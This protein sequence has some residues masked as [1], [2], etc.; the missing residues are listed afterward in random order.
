MCTHACVFGLAPA[1]RRLTAHQ[2]AAGQTTARPNVAGV[3]QQAGWAG[4]ALMWI[5][6]LVATIG[7]LHKAVAKARGMHQHAHM[8][9]TLCTIQASL[10]PRTGPLSGSAYGVAAGR[11]QGGSAGQ[12]M[13]GRDGESTLETMCVRVKC[14]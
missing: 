2:T 11:V 7:D 8:T 6:W 12:G 4:L 10:S 5:G 14:R 3:A 1:G 13:Q 9:R